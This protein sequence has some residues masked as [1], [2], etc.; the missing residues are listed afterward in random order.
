MIAVLGDVHELLDEMRDVV[1]AL[2][3]NVRA[4]IQVG[5]L[6][7]WPPAPP[8]G[9]GADLP[10]APSDPRFRWRRLPRPIYY[11]DG[12]HHLYPLT[13]GVTRPTEVAPGL[14]YLPR[15]TVLTLPGLGGPCRVGVLG[16]ADS[17]LDRAFRRPGTDWWPQEERVTTADVDHLVAN[18]RLAGGVDLLITHTPP[19][20]VTQA[21]T[22]RAPH[23]SA[24]LVEQ[25]WRALG[26]PECVSGHMHQ[27]AR[28]GG[29][30]VLAML[31]VTY[32]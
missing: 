29:C 27:S 12:N 5:D 1:D 18:A 20:C 24:V 9:A 2:P 19:G 23:P 10:P 3:R 13:R 26:G 16:G 6:W 15:G 30:Q 14:A 4:V 31:E 28:V 32:R 25:A 7:A 21:M 17:V 22:G 11:L 8:H